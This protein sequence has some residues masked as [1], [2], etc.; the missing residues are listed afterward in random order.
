M[1][2]REAW[3]TDAVFGDSFA[4]AGARLA[5]YISFFSLDGKGEIRTGSSFHTENK[6]ACIYTM[7]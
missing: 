5:E 7:G 3:N 2:G 1:D 6:F 4:G